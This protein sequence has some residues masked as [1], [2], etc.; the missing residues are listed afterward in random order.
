MMSVIPGLSMEVDAHEAAGPDDNLFGMICRYQEA[1]NFYPSAIGGNGY[2]GITKRTGGQVLVISNPLLTRSPAV[3]RGQE[4]NHLR[5]ICKGNKLSLY[6]NDQLVA[7]ATENDFQG[8]D[9]GLLAS[10]GNQAGVEIHFTNFELPRP[11]SPK[12]G[13]GCSHGFKNSVFF[14]SRFLWKLR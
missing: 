4:S 3:I 1:N 6:V 10:A 13:L 12:S 5:A 14:S 8:G 7:Q 2:A 9:V 11:S